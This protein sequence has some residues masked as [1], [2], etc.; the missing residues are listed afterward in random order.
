MG[1]TRLE[2]RGRVEQMVGSAFTDGELNEA[3]NQAIEAAWPVIKQVKE[4]TSITLDEDYFNYAVTAT[5]ISEKGIAEVYVVRSDKPDK[6]LRRAVDRQIETQ[7]RVYFTEDHIS[8]YEGD[9]IICRY[10]AAY[11]RL[12]DD[13]T[14]TEVP[15][16]FIA[17][18]AASL[19]AILAQTR[20]GHFNVEGFARAA[21]QWMELAERAKKRQRSKGLVKLIGYT[22]A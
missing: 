14:E 13:T 21:P 20:E 22:R 10:E 15:S 18:Y 6:L 3:I 5:D 4:D 7:W 9:S 2:A 12:T 1:I 19:V 11:P 8:D 16:D 17:Y